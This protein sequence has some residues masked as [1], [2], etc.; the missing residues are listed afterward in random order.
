MPGVACSSETRVIG[1][2]MLA[3]MDNLKARVIR[4]LL[5]KHHLTDIWPDQ[6]YPLKPWLNVLA[7]LSS[8]PD[9]TD[10]MIAVGLKLSEYA[11][12]PPDMNGFSL[13]QMLEGWNTLLQANH[14][15]G[16]IG[17][18]TTEKITDRLYRTTHLNVYPD[19][20]NYGFA[21]GLAQSLLPPETPF[22]VWY[23]DYYHRLDVG[24][25]D[26]TVICV[27]WE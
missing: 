23:E 15:K 7:N 9:Y 25:G 5:E 14:Q 10:I 20:V 27:R 17:Q 8:R 12:R 1:Q 4:P 2:I 3:Y 21:Y 24:D 26:K 19:D 11:I 18:I 16:Y 13:G 6:W 22:E